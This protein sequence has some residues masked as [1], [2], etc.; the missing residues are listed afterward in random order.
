MNIDSIKNG[1][2]ID[3]IK[4]GKSMELYHYLNLENLNCSVAIIK[5]VVSKKM[6]RKDI[7]KIDE[8]I[9]LNLDVLGYVDPDTTVNI[10]KDGVRIE[11]RHPELPM[12][13]VNVIKCK[14]PRCITTTEQEIA[15]I[16]KLT[17]RKN[18]VYR[19][20]YCESKAKTS[21]E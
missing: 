2:V 1:I 13:L 7:I 5:N 21:K 19:C 3:H 18:R 9:H 14:N 16:F 12:Q 17:D 11:K 4:A 6:G 20:I 15:Q 8:D 10:I